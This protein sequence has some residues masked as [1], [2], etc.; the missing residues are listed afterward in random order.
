MKYVMKSGD[1]LHKALEFLKTVPRPEMKTQEEL[2]E[3]YKDKYFYEVMKVA[4]DEFRV[5]GPLTDVYYISNAPGFLKV[6]DGKPIQMF[7]E[8]EIY[9][10]KIPL[11]GKLSKT[12]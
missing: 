4:N 2:D 5:R 8:D 11:V 1:E 10:T 12:F 3:M 7:T 6:I 9:V